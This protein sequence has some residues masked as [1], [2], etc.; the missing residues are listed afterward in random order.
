[1]VVKLFHLLVFSSMSLAT[2]A[3]SDTSD[4][5]ISFLN[6]LVTEAKKSQ[7]N[8]GACKYLSESEKLLSEFINYDKYLMEAEFTDTKKDKISVFIPIPKPGR[9]GLSMTINLSG[10][11]CV[12]FEL[13]E[14]MN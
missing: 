12:G 9:P 4:V 11:E 6:H 3:G 8:D 1:M 10:G 2:M 5:D 14:I 7:S 13:H